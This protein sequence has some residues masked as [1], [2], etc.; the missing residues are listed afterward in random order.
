MTRCCRRIRYPIGSGKR[1]RTLH[2]THPT[3]PDQSVIEKSESPRAYD[4][5]R[6]RAQER[7]L[8][9]SLSLSY[10]SLIL[11]RA[12]PYLVGAGM[13]ISAFLI[14]AWTIPTGLL[15]APLR[16]I[17]LSAFLIC[18]LALLAAARHIKIPTQQEALRHLDRASPHAHRPAQSLIDH[19]A[20]SG[21]KANS[22]R[23]WD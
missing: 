10:A 7:G 17:I 18:A 14:Y 6:Q 9:G 13:L 3:H 16:L 23:L 11:E 21:L 8:W 5:A 4:D 15:P 2:L 12:W 1:D 20:Q 22:N 19:P